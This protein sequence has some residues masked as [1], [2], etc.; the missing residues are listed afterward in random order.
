MQRM[1]KMVAVL[2]ALAPA[3]FLAVTNGCSPSTELGGVRI[4]NAVPD[5][6]I[7][8]MPPVLEQTDIV[9]EFFWTGSD[10]DGNIRGFQWKM[11]SNG[12]DGI[13]VQDTL[14]VDPA[15]GDTLHPWNFT[16]A[17]DTIFIVS[18]DSSGFDQDDILPEEL[19]RFFQPHTLFVRAVD[20]EGAVDPTPA[21]ITFTATT[22]APSIRLTTPPSLT[23]NYDDARGVPPSF[24]LGW[25]GND[26]DFETEMPTKVRYLL[27]DAIIEVEGGDPLPVSSRYRFERYKDEL[28]SFS[29]PGWSDWI[30]YEP[31]EEDRRV[32]FTKPAEA[33]HY[34]LF[35][36]QAQDTAGAVSLDLSYAGTVHNFRIDDSKSPSLSVQETFLGSSVSAGLNGIVRYDIAQNQP[37]EFTWHANADEYGGLI[38][39]FRYGWDIDDV[40]N[41]AD[42]G[43]A[44]Q[45][46]N[47]DA[48]RESGIQ[49]FDSGIH[50]LVVEVRDNSGQ[51]T[52]VR[53]VMTVVPVP[54]PAD[55]RPLLLIDDVVDHESN[56]W[57]DAN[58]RAY[59]EDF[60]RDAFWA[61]VLGNVQGWGDDADEIDAQDTQS[62]GYREAVNYKVLMWTTKLGSLSYIQSNFVPSTTP[63]V[64]VWLETYLTN[65]G[66]LFMVGSGAMQ[67]FGPRGTGNT[68]WLYPVIYDTDEMT[69]MC[70]NQPYALGFGIREDEDENI[71]LRGREKFPYRAIGLSMTNL[72]TPPVFWRDSGICGNNT[73]HLLRRCGGTK[74]VILDPEFKANHVGSNAFADTVF[75]W[76]TIDYA[77]DSDVLNLNF[78]FG[79]IDEFYDTNVTSRT[80]NWAP[81]VLP[82]GT[83]AV[84]PMWRAYTRFDWILDEHLAAGD[85][86]FPGG[87][88]VSAQ[89]YC[90]SWTVDPTTGR[91]RTDGVPVGILSYKTA[92]TKPGGKAD[93]IWGFDPHRMDHDEMA[94]AIRWVLREH[95]ELDVQ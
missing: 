87:I 14:T 80:T 86:D 78:A 3:V 44:V 7:T 53:Y 89:I 72:M 61:G 83:P 33:D 46:G 26:P 88:D 51:L 18:A 62:W 64:F 12:E 8:G 24:I 94:D 81:Q 45:W 90:G 16:T 67:N 11:T 5:T 82:D 68:L 71:I 10:P 1:T 30:T 28:V 2:L 93:V 20:E 23:R 34:Y 32:T 56:G 63:D 4:I 76:S 15:T 39:A 27:K 54:E 48:H 59:D 65:V 43:W 41:D 29:D 55:Q 70:G 37:L 92:L 22:L 66:N 50:T 42:P 17:T 57:R 40:E 73:Q 84:E 21:M 75:T 69:A 74:A 19:Q 91:A 95:F 9:V 35:A 49:T 85:T 36:M 25:T 38:D 31:M 47:S 52:R 6:R 13:S 58:G 60:Y 79:G 77:D